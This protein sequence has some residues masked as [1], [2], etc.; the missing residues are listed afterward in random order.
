VTL[1][2]ENTSGVALTARA[3][4]IEDALRAFAMESLGMLLDA[5]RDMTDVPRQ[6]A[7]YY[8]EKAREIRRLAWRSRSADVSRDLFEIAERF[9]RMADHVEKRIRAVAD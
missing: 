3:E 9:D 2:I 4:L 5:V 1:E 7:D 6:I 8:R